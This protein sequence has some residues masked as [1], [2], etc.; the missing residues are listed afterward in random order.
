MTIHDIAYDVNEKWGYTVY[1]EENGEYVP[2][3]VLSGDYGGNVLVSLNE[4]KEG[5]KAK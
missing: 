5:E 4:K 3:L 1:L 2:Y